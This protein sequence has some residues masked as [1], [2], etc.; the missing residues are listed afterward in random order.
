VLG[1]SATMP[2]HVNAVQ[3]V[4]SALDTAEPARPVK[5]I[6]GGRA[7]DQEPNLWRSLGADGYAADAGAA[8]Q[9]AERLVRAGRPRG[10]DTGPVRGGPSGGSDYSP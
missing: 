9:T 5:I 8:V 10:R 2:Y 1:I 6:V 7:F 3:A 4:I